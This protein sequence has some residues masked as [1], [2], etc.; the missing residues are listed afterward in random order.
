MEKEKI[1]KTSVDSKKE[2]ELE[3]KLTKLITYL[4]KVR[5]LYKQYEIQDHDDQ[6][7]S[8]MNNF[9]AITNQ[10]SASENDVND[11]TSVVKT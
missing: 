6:F 7:I 4:P 3:Q 1:A 2:K 8:M 11:A 10:Q 5:D 9:K